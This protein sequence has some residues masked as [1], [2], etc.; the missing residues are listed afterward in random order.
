M[1]LTVALLGSLLSLA[2][3]AAPPPG[4]KPA[5]AP[6]P[7]ASASAGARPWAVCE[8]LG[9]QAIALG[10]GGAPRGESGLED[11]S[12]W[13]ERVRRCPTVP[14]LL[15]LAARL[16]L[17]AAG[18]VGF[19]HEPGTSLDA[20][21][22]DHRERVERAAQWAKTALQESARRREPPPRETRFVLAYAM[23]SLGRTADA[24]AALDRAIAAA[25]IERWRSDRMGAVIALLDGDL[26]GAMALAQRATIDAPMDDRT[27]TRYI[28]AMV[29]DRAGGTAA[30]HAEL[31]D[32][33]NEAGSIIARRATE[34]LLP[35]HERLYLRALDH[36]VAEDSGTALR[37][38]DAYLSRSE[39]AEPERVLA[40]RHRAELVRK[41]APVR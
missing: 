2:P 25:E 14:G 12:V 37:L 40:R 5:A 33:R 10:N 30:A 34:S 19:V 24:R 4:W 13:L 22:N 1:A 16:E 28:R 21:V 20:V 15:V 6:P 27:I 11:N 3:Q 35:V 32:L 26:D 29:L 7:S 23:L 39:P 31:L 41:P 38:W 8:E 9:R 17:V 36:Q 18:D